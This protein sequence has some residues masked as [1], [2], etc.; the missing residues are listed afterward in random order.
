MRPRI[1]LTEGKVVRRKAGRWCPCGK[2]A[3]SSRKL[4][5]TTAKR[6]TRQAGEDVEAYHDF[7]CHAWHVG[8]PPEPYDRDV[9]L[10]L[11]PPSRQR[12]AS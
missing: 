7:R 9:A 3:Y 11:K 4:A 6:Q 1:R 10:G 12:K 8:H 2:V 5:T